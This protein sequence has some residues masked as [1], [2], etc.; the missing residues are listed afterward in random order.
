MLQFLNGTYEAGVTPVTTYNEQR[1]QSAGRTQRCN[2]FVKL[3]HGTSAPDTLLNMQTDSKS[4]I[5]RFD[6]KLVGPYCCAIVVCS[7]VFVVLNLR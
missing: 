3:A 4:K 7:I 2:V 6:L 1:F 5:L